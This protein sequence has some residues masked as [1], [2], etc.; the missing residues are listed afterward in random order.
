[1][2]APNTNPIGYSDGGLIRGAYRLNIDGSSF[3]LK[4]GKI[5]IP[6]REEK[7]YGAQGQ[8]DSANYVEDFSTMSVTIMAKKGMVDPATK[9]FR[10]FAFKGD[11]WVLASIDFA[12]S[13]QGLQ[14]YTGQINKLYNDPV[15]PV[16]DES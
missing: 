1:M 12:F 3:L 2:G 10:P 7:E 9:R 4:E 14:V 11:V 8:P 16:Y 15:E 6:V 5:A 13:T